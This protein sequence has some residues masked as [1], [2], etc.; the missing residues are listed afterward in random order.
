MTTTAGSSTWWAPSDDLGVCHASA[1]SLDIL[2]CGRCGCDGSVAQGRCVLSHHRT[3]LKL[4]SFSPLT[5]TI[6]PAEIGPSIGSSPMGQR[7]KTLHFKGQAQAGTGGGA[8]SWTSARQ[9]IAAIPANHR[10]IRCT[11]R[12]G[13]R[14]TS[15]AL[16]SFRF[17]P[18]GRYGRLPAHTREDRDPHQDAGAA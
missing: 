13:D 1:G 9:R 15:G 4:L 17:G 6:P 14:P 11:N 12:P 2:D 7:L 8:R 10:T 5:K 16:N 18:S 3:A